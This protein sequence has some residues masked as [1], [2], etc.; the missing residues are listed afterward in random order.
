VWL[1]SPTQIVTDLALNECIFVEIQSA[2][3]L[4]IHYTMTRMRSTETKIN[5][6]L[7]GR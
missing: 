3:C 1:T 5:N 6:T 7:P 4:N 2:V